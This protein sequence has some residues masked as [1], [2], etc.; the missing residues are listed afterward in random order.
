MKGGKRTCQCSAQRPSMADRIRFDL[1][2]SPAGRLIF[3]KLLLFL[4]V[5]IDLTTQTERCKHE[6]R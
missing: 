6:S 3:F 1:L 5:F 2:Q 4:V